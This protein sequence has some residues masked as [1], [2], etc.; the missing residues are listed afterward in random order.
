MFY[1]YLTT[2]ANSPRLWYF[3]YN[4]LT[5]FNGQ[6]CYKCVLS[7]Y[8]FYLFPFVTVTCIIICW[9]FVSLTIPHDNGPSSVSVS[10]ISQDPILWHGHFVHSCKAFTFS[11]TC[12]DLLSTALCDLLGIQCKFLPHPPPHWIYSVCVEIIK[13]AREER[14]KKRRNLKSISSL[15]RLFSIL[16][17]ITN[18]GFIEF[19]ASLNK[20]KKYLDGK[21]PV[22]ACRHC[23]KKPAH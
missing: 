17:L 13:K 15:P 22:C 19:Q 20:W 6:Q 18:Y 16:C 10:L 8:I 3:S 12:I 7:G 21:K 5:E 2:D 4:F 14:R 1:S 9:I 23:I 11:L